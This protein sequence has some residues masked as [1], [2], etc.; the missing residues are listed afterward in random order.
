MFPSIFAL[1]EDVHHVDGCLFQH[2]V[3]DVCINIRRGLV[4]AVPDDLHGDQRYNASFVKHVDVILPEEMRR[5]C[6]LDLLPDVFRTVGVNVDFAP[7]NSAA[8]H[9]QPEP[10]PSETSFGN[11]FAFAGLENVRICQYSTDC[12]FQSVIDSCNQRYLIRYANTGPHQTE[13]LT[14]GISVHRLSL[15]HI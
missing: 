5:Q 13:T 6:G 14:E 8:V 2:V 15:I 3:A 9:H 12:N 1:L 7:F 11:R 10:H 4:V